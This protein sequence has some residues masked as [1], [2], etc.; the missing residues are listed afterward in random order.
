MNIITDSKTAPL[1]DSKDTEA[2]SLVMD[3]YQQWIETK[4]YK[5]RD[6]D[7]CFENWRFYWAK[8][9]ELGQGQWPQAAV[10][11]MNQQGRYL[12]Q[13]NFIKPTID[14]VVGQIMQNPFDPEFRP[15][16][17]EVDSL[18]HAIKHAFY[19]DKEQMNWKAAFLEYVTG[20]L[21]FEG[22]MKMIVS[23]RLHPLGN[24]GL[25]TCLPGSVIFDPHWKTFSSKDAEFCFT[26][27]WMT[28]QAIV[29]TWPDME[30]IIGAKLGSSNNS[31]TYGPNTGIVPYATNENSWGSLYRVISKYFMAKVK[32]EQEYVITEKG[33]I[34]IPQMDD[35]KKP[36]WLNR[37][38]P[39]W[40]PEQIRKIPEKQKL[41]FVNTVC[42]SLVNTQAVSKGKTEIQI[43]RLPFFKWSASRFNGE[44]SGLL[45]SL[46]DPQIGLNYGEAMVQYYLQTQGGGGAHYVDPG[47]FKNPTEYGKFTKHRN[48]GDQ[49]IEVRP[50]LLEE[51]KVPAKPISVVPFNRAVYDNLTHITETVWPRVS[52]VTPSM[53]GRP[54]TGNQT[55]GRLFEMMKSQSDNQLYSIHYGL[56][57]N[58][59]E[60]Y[61]AY[62][63][64][65][66]VQYSLEGVP[67]DF[68]YDGQKV[69]LNQPIEFP[70]GSTGIM[71]DASKLKE[72][73]HNV[74][75]DEVQE[76]PTEK[77]NNVMILSEYLRT[78]PPESYGTRAVVSGAIGRNI[79]QFSEEDKAAIV[80]MQQKEI[81]LAKAKIDMDT[82]NIKAQTMQLQLSIQSMQAQQAG[83]VP[84]GEEGAGAE[85]GFPGMSGIE[86]KPAGGSQLNVPLQ[87]NSQSANNQIPAASQALL[88]NKNAQAQQGGGA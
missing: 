51:G 47:S 4:A 54:E 25:E 55:S 9:P 15:V 49:N 18:T 12:V 52:K 32:T 35:L 11:R 48:R 45:D 78:I 56:R 38:L 10:D 77:T 36:E 40:Q 60:V 43:E 86:G 19:S 88:G 87:V 20:G 62:L 70:D 22:V 68:Y 24:I 30:S 5:R 50:G 31:G 17:S 1:T 73:R 44:D 27:S 72:F 33:K 3:I 13:Y 28:A 59:K 83:M 26:E 23:D 66:A 64:Q 84:P 61:E 34:A 80:Q 69:T 82:M 14:A 76:S 58:Y 7:N 71:N 41:C 74:I 37:N 16:N 46:K 81:E 57:E 63:L 67:R 75:I 42:P 85:G 8:N 65:A 6:I 2:N 21:I 79:D 39:D 53:T 29:D